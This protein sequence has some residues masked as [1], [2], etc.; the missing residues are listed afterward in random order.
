[1]IVVGSDTLDNFN[2]TRFS[3]EYTVDGLDVPN[4]IAISTDP[5]A[6][7]QVDLPESLSALRTTYA[8]IEVVAEDNETKKTYT[9]GLNTTAVVTGTE[10]VISTSIYPNPFVNKINIVSDEVFNEVNVLDVNGRVLIEKVFE[11]SNK[12][13]INLSDLS[14]GQYLILVKFENNVQ[15]F[16]IIK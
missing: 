12:L 5:N 15:S 10:E 7:V 13:D 6:D 4:V 9:V 2:P 11:K 16:K 8:V 14:S 3:Y 1:M